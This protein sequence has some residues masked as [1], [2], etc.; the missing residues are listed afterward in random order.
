MPTGPQNG[1]VE[2]FGMGMPATEVNNE[3]RREIEHAARF[4]RTGEFKKL[5]EYLEERI[6]YFQAYLPDGRAVTT[7]PKAELE[8]M[9][10]AANVII[11]EYRNVLAVYDQ[12][13]E[14]VKETKRAR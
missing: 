9:W 13:R 2:D 10:V 8:G 12:A 7:V 1:L 14:T 11:G 6:A 4:S 3:A 5:Q